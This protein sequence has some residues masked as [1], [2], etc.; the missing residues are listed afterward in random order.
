MTLST[1]VLIAGLSLG[2]AVMA[3]GLVNTRHLQARV[4]MLH[5]QCIAEGE[6][7]ATVPGSYSALAAE[8]GGKLACDPMELVNSTGANNTSGTQGQLVAAQR[9]ALDSTQWPSFLGTAIACFLAIPSAWYFLLR[10]LKEIREA[11][12]GQSDA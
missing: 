2:V 4:E 12:S 5:A 8:Y 9:K 3:A 11:L 6:K 1:K 7:Q 10:R